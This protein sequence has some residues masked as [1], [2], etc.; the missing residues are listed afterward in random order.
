MCQPPLF[1]KYNTIHPTFGLKLEPKHI[2]CR[3]TDLY[4]S[5]RRWSLGVSSLLATTILSWE[6]RC[7]IIYSVSSDPFQKTRKLQ[8]HHKMHN[9]STTS[10]DSQFRNTLTTTTISNP[11]MEGGFGLFYWKKRKSLLAYTTS[12]S[13][14]T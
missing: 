5:G 11:Q 9:K 7:A 3:R 10:Q 13:A 1:R 6:S 8:R 2:Y 14:P 4:G 12:K